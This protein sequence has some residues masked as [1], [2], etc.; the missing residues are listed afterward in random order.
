MN[1]IKWLYQKINPWEDITN[2]MLLDHLFN[3]IMVWIHDKDE[4]YFIIDEELINIYFYYFVYTNKTIVV[5]DEYY[6]LKYSDDMVN[7][8][9]ELKEI[10]KSY[11]S[12][13]FDEKERTSDDLFHFLFTYISDNKEIELM[14]EDAEFEFIEYE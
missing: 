12:L 14:E 1:F 3:Q 7:L 6:S 13:L 10:S 5:K 9:I 8:F 2:N 11:G 4:L